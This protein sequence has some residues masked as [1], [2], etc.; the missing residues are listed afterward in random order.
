M[1]FVLVISLFSSLCWAGP[2][3]VLGPV[4]EP[5]LRYR[6]GLPSTTETFLHIDVIDPVVFRVVFGTSDT[7]VTLG[8]M[9]KYFKGEGSPLKIEARPDGKID[10]LVMGKQNKFF[11]G[12]SVNQ[13][14][15]DGRLYIT[16]HTGVKY[17]LQFGYD[18]YRR[19]VSVYAVPKVGGQWLIF[20]AMS[21]IEIEM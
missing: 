7:N 15:P 19:T 1:R 18:R 2:D 4:C 13:R 16:N 11:Q 17:A 14:L 8:E 21:G 9:Y 12:L 3:A 20:Q 5:A 6:W 10:F